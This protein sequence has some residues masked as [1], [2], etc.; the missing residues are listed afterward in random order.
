MPVRGSIR[1]EEAEKR[2]ESILQK[3]KASN[4]KSEI[5]N[6]TSIKNVQKEDSCQDEEKIRQNCIKGYKL[7]IDDTLDLPLEK[8]VLTPEGCEIFDILCLRLDV[9]QKYVDL[10]PQWRDVAHILQLDDL[11]TKWVEVCVRPKEGLTRAML[12]IYMRDG[13]TLG[14]V[15]EALLELECLDILEDTKPKVDVYIKKKEAG[16]LVAMS[17]FANCENF[18]SIIKTLAVALGNQDPCRDVHKYANGLKNKKNTEI[19]YE[20]REHSG[21]V[22]SVPEVMNNDWPKYTSD[23]HLNNLDSLR[24]DQLLPKKRTICKILVI[25]AEDGVAD[26]QNAIDI[27]KTVQN[28]ECSIEL[29][30]LNESTLWYEVLV[31]P[32]ACCMKWASE[33]DYIMPILTPKFLQEIHGKICG[34]NDSLGLLPTSPV[35]NKYMYN[36]ARSQYTQNGCKN[37]KVRP[38]IP[39]HCLTQ[40]KN[41]NAVRMDP[42]LAHTWKALKE[43]MVKSRFKALMAECIKRRQNPIT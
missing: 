39:L 1:I 22:E 23:L 40:V 27:S 18:F 9:N 34:N 41:S 36:L 15:L 2:K 5:P 12:E 33:A 17:N 42:L 29:I 43:D 19:S 8:L 21:L 16:D 7:M 31:N 13:G 35:L 28:E 30:R 14:E 20:V 32:E 25:F 4:V 38:L 6:E 10:L 37:L 26:S 11:A 3:I 24:R